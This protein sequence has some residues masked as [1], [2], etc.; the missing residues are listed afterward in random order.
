[1]TGFAVIGCGGWGGL[2]A[3][4]VTRVRHAE[5]IGVVD[6]SAP[7]AAEVADRL[8]TQVIASAHDAFSDQRVDAVAIAV[9]NDL[10]VD[11]CRAALVAGKHVLLEKPM[12]LTVAEADE[13]TELAQERGL[14]LGVDHIQRY[15]EPL[16]TLRQLVAEGELGELQA[17]SIARRDFLERKTPWLQ[18]RRRVG[19]LLYQSGCHEFDFVCWLCGD[20]V[21]IRC[22]APPRVIAQETLD[23]PDTILSQLRFASGAVADVWDCMTDPTM[24][25]DCA[26]TG[27]RG[28]AFVDL[29]G[30]RLRWCQIH[31]EPRKRR[32]TPPERWAPWAWIA[33]GGIAEGESEALRSLLGDFAAAVEG[34]A[35]FEISGR[36]GAR[37]VELAQ[38]GYLSLAENRPVSLPLRGSDRTRRTYLELEQPTAVT[39]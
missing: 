1:M 13:V 14:I 39:T 12:A 5:L 3:A 8:E 27:T 33:G 20:A 19:G 23:Y 30:A 32:W 35:T 36:D 24:S 18:Q 29:Y 28:S 21:E 11:L 4:E 16:A 9:P 15:Y 6:E 25:Y 34:T 26:V 22:V 37:V 31:G 10:H 2:I 38:A 17:V 7:R